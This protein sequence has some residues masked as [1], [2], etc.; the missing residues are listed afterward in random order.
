LTANSTK[1]EKAVLDAVACISR[2]KDNPE[3]AKKIAWGLG[4]IAQNTKSE[5]AVLD[6]VARISSFDP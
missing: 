1:S 6:A 2:Y 5:K 3:V 4:A